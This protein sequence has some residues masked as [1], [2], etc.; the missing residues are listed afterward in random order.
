MCVKVRERESEGDERASEQPF[1]CPERLET[2][3]DLIADG[4]GGRE[5]TGRGRGDKRMKL[6]KSFM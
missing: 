4:K 6:C 3:N 5:K 1:Y 2:Q